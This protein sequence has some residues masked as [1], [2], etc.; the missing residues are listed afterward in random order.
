MSKNRLEHC[1]ARVENYVKYRPSYPQR[2][3]DFL[4]TEG[5]FSRESVIADIG[6]GTGLFTRLLLERGSRVIAVE[7]DNIM[8]TIA[9]R[10][11]GD[12]FQRFVSI[13]GTAENTT[14][15]DSSVNH[16]VCAQSF[17]WFDLE[18][19]KYE[20]VRILKPNGTVTIIRNKRVVES[21]AFSLAYEQLLQRCTLKLEKRQLDQISETELSKFFGS[22][23]YSVISLPNQQVLDQDGIKGRFLSDDCIPVLDEEGY[24]E[25]IIE[26]GQLFD[27]FNQSGKVTL[28]YET[29]AYAGRFNIA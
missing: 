9:E 24:N 17:H 5:G 19:C 3:I 15:P 25:T 26:L 29:E 13:M 12:E 23:C 16:I 1:P 20:F 22:E 7:P 14:L 18:K 21:D 28:R 27:Q 6:S 11:L 4:Y 10:L 8:R 2:L